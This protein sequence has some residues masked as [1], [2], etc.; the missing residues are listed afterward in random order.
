MAAAFAERERDRRGLVLDVRS[1]GTHPA[2]EVHGVVVDVMDEAGFDLSGN[3]P[4]E[5]TTDELEACAYVATMGCSTLSLDADLDVRA[6]NL[7]NPNGADR[8]TAWEIRDAVE[9]R[10]SALFDDIVAD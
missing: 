3:T 9:R 1:G 2:D 4:K 7:D 8:E 6:W 5:I 10:V